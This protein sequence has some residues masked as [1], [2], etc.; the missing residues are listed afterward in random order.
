MMAGSKT[1]IFRGVTGICVIVTATGAAGLAL[2]GPASAKP[3]VQDSYIEVPQCQPATSQ[4]CPQIPTA[5]IG[6]IMSPTVSFTANTNH[7]SDIIAHVFIDGEEFGSDLL[8]PGETTPDFPLADL[9]PHTVGI[10]AEGI[11]G[12]CNRGWVDAWGGTLHF[13]GTLPLS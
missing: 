10:Q 9:Q 11:P 2:A 13:R 3:F 4:L 12:G 6:A 8:E 5:S 1:R 7:C